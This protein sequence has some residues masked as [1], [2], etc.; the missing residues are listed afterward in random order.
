M[1]TRASPSMRILVISDIHYASPAEQQRVGYEWATVSSRWQRMLLRAYRHAI[2]LR[3][4]FAH[5]SLLDWFVAQAGDAELVV[6]NG[7][8]SCDSAFVG[9][10][11]DAA[12]Q[13]A[14]LCL[15]R[16]RERFGATFQAVIGDHELGKTSLAGN[17][18]GMRLASW[19][20]ATGE[21][22]LLPCWR[23]DLGP[24][25]VLGLTSSL[26]A[27]PV[28]APEIP[29]ADRAAWEQLRE[30]HCREI[31]RQLETLAPD[32]RLLL[33]LHDPTALPFLA[34]LP[35]MRARLDQ[36]AA[37]VI[38]HLHSPLIL[39][40]SRMLAG[41]PPIRRLGNAVR[42]MSQALNQAHSWRPFNLHLCPSLAGLELL[43]DGG[44]LELVLSQ[45]GRD[46]PVVRRQRVPRA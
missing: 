34:D 13:S 5:N 16:L 38:G 14:A 30:D 45:D 36:V 33:F 6:A 27:L 40:K 23:V 18:G 12:A 10:S 22:G 3:D 7:D 37:T 42:R 26:L 8:Y 28:L 19:Q 20:R 4:P 35:P 17:Q 41:L 11:D 32:R 2:W 9:V 24:W 25:V 43:K 1:R 21:L 39:W 46:P 31:S 15:G 29:P 44:F